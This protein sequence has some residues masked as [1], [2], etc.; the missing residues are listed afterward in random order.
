[1]APTVNF[2]NDMVIRSMKYEFLSNKVTK[3]LLIMLVSD[4]LE[5]EGYYG[6]GKGR[7]RC[8][9]RTNCCESARTMDTVLIDSDTYLLVLL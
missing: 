3:Q 5:Q 2:V 8:F 6:P 9:V 4:A 1:M 7:C